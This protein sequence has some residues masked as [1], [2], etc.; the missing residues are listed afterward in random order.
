MTEARLSDAHLA[1]LACPHDHSALRWAP[2]ALIAHL[3]AEID[4]KCLRDAS[5]QLVQHTLDAGLLR[6]DGQRL[7]GV[8]QGLP[9]LRVEAAIVLTD[10]EHQLAHAQLAS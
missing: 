10:A 9:V 2:A 1:L 7:Y 6:A 5:G 4:R 8:V 3:N